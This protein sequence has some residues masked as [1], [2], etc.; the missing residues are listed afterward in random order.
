MSNSNSDKQ[1]QRRRNIL[2]A[3]TGVP[4]IFTLPT[5]AALAN[6]SLTC[7]DKSKTLANQSPPA[8]LKTE[9]DTWVRL[10]VPIYKIRLNKP[11]STTEEVFAF[12]LNSQWYRVTAPSTVTN[13]TSTRDSSYTQVQQTGNYY[14]L[15]DQQKYKTSSPTSPQNYVFLGSENAVTSPVSGGS[16]WNSINPGANMGSTNTLN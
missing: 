1:K 10:S 4:V 15:V 16:C 14:L 2:K 6:T 8:G 12:T 5:G 11:D 7:V 13:V 3:A 9:T